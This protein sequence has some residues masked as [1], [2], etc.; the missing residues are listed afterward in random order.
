MFY[1]CDGIVGVFLYMYIEILLKIFDL[2]FYKGCLFRYLFLIF[3]KVNK[4]M[5]IYVD[6]M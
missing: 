3:R 4:I 6:V 1:K 5:K 2:V